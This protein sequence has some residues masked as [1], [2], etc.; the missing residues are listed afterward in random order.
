MY[1]KFDL[2]FSKHI[3]SYKLFKVDM[4]LTHAY[5]KHNIFLRI[6]GK[7]RE[8]QGVTGGQHAQLFSVLDLDNVVFS[9]SSKGQ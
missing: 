3:F 2:S 7:G 8:K 5:T 9:L 1:V 4:L 6:V